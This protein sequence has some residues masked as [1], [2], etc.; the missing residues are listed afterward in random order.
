LKQST[1]NT[2]IH[3]V[4][5]IQDVRE[6]TVYGTA[7]LPF[8][9]AMLQQEHLFPYSSNGK[10]ELAITATALTWKGLKFRELI[11]T[12]S[13]CADHHEAHLDGF[14]LAHAFNS[15]YSLAFA[16]RFFFKTPYYP[17]NI[18]ID[19]NIPSR[20]ELSDK[21]GTLFKATMSHPRAPASID[22]RAWQG[23]VFLP[24]RMTKQRE[25]GSKFFVSLSG[26]QIIYPFSPSV[27]QMMI[28]PSEAHSIFEWLIDSNFTA[29]EWRIRRNAQHAKSK[30]YPRALDLSV[31]R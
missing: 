18:G 27:D 21:H 23:P 14:Y 8:W 22:H 11:V 17:G 12:V 19:E 16:E 3:Y 4:A 15:S 7:D 2:N 25:L 20:I 10:A 29:T 31:Q 9:R 28:M 6:V 24:K 1:P 26:E 5:E 30:T 13:I